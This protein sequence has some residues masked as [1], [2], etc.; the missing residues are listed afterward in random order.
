M[1]TY[2]HTYIHNTYVHTCPLH[3]MLTL[4]L[5][6]SPQA[7]APAAPPSPINHAAISR[8]FKLIKHGPVRQEACPYAHL[9]L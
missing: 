2:I 3:V 4:P 7:A 6:F 5:L 1:H 8:T 9:L